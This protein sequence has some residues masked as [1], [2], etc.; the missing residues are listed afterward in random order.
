MLSDNALVDDGLL[1]DWKVSSGE[2]NILYDHSDNGNHGSIERASYS[3][4]IPS[5]GYTDPYANNFN[6][7][8]NVDDGSCSGY[9]NG[10]F[11]LSFDGVDDLVQI[12]ELFNPNDFQLYLY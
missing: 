2:G 9:R 1:A 12:N 5:F 6:P 10:Q 7:D 3:A 8:A 4:E 11:S